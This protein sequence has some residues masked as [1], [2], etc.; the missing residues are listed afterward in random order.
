MLFAASVDAGLVPFYAFTAFLA[1]GEYTGDAVHWDTLFEDQGATYRITYATFL[2]SII[3][4]GFHL[5]SMVLSIY[6]AV[7]FRQISKLPPDMNPLED[8]LTSRHYEHNK[9]ELAE[10]HLSQSTF[11][12]Y[13]NRMSAA[14][15]PSTPQTRSTPFMHTRQGSSNNG[16]NDSSE[17][18]HEMRSSQMSA[19]SK[20]SSR[21]Q[22]PSQQTRLYEQPNKSNTSLT[23]T[24][25][26]KA[27]DSPSRPT[28]AVINDAPVL[29]PS[30]AASP[31]IRS[32]SP[33]PTLSKDNWFTYPSRS[34]SPVDDAHNKN[35]ARRET[36]SVYSR[37]TTLASSTYSGPKDWI[38]SAERYDREG[39][40]A[41]AEDRRGE[42]EALVENEYYGDDED[43]QRH[44]IYDD[45]EQDLGERPANISSDESKKTRR[46][47]P[48]NPLGMN[49]PTPKPK[50]DGS[51]KS[52]SSKGSVRRTALTDIPN[53]SVKTPD[54]MPPLESP[55]RKGRFYGDLESKIG[56]AISWDASRTSETHVF[57]ESKKGSVK[58]KVLRNKSGKLA[59]Y[60]SLKVHDD[61]SS[62]P[63]DQDSKVKRRSKDVE[64]DRKGRV[65]SNSG[66]DIGA[67]FQLGSGPSAS[68]GSY[69]AGLGVG[70]RREVSG[71][72]AEEGRGGTG[73]ADREKTPQKPPYPR[74]AGQ[75]VIRAAGWARFAG[76]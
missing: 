15:E 36:S 48:F 29:E 47:L 28:S 75:N 62:G 38:T 9:S 10:K 68:Y 35:I 49:P 34:P 66:V 74:P 20:Q 19:H 42:Y 52:R 57:N 5:V 8:N 55:E 13:G 50:E 51:I 40:N 30:T 72:L 71:K 26:L 70:R 60:Q 73:L 2:V 12:S 23:R 7:I 18:P 4:G 33:S 65:V 44:E 1:H 67:G 69:I 25:A 53:P 16:S 58:K 76:L 31:E 63:E 22:L 59:S 43:P 11:E 32:G 61:D 6:L 45:M 54:P 24:P 17:R 3:N 41:S 39:S 14:E 27:R 46:E 21:A 56:L 37:A 64:G